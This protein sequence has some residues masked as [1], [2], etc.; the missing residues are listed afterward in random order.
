M[1]KSSRYSKTPKYSLVTVI[2]YYCNNMIFFT[3]N[4]CYFVTIPYHHGNDRTPESAHH[5]FIHWRRIW[6]RSSKRRIWPTDVPRPYTN[7]AH[8]LA[9]FIIAGRRWRLTNGVEV[10]Q[11]VLFSIINSIFYVTMC[12]YSSLAVFFV[13]FAVLLPSCKLHI[14]SLFLLDVSLLLIKTQLGGF[15]LVRILFV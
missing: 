15:N 13:S 12:S 11:F 10:W 3:D 9:T 2:K 4:C 5:A 14:N 8:L 1:W 7:F 6:V